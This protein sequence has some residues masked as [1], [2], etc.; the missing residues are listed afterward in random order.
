MADKNE[1][2][3]NRYRQMLEEIGTI[4]Q[5]GRKRAYSAVNDVLV[6][7]YWNIGREI[8]EYEQ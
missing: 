1:I 4:L 6:E 5:E 2:M 8:V 3:S 7:T